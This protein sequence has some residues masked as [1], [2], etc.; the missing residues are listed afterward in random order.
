MP[1]F[2]VRTHQNMQQP[3]PVEVPEVPPAVR[4]ASDATAVALD[5]QRE[6]HEARERAAAALRVAEHND[7]VAEADA[8]RAG[9]KPPKPA[10]PGARDDLEAAERTF[11]LRQRLTRDAKLELLRQIAEHRD[12]WLAAT[13]ATA[14][15][16][17]ARVHGLLSDLEDA[18]TAAAS[19]GDAV[20]KL[21]AFDGRLI[22]LR[23]APEVGGN[24]AMLPARSSVLI[25][26]IATMAARACGEQIGA[27]TVD[28]NDRA[29]QRRRARKLAS[30]EANQGRAA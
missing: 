3:I 28:I 24:G 10:A 19:A 14:A 29:K 11:E 18:L 21:E 20:A 22:D 8:L 15:D 12:D 27:S 30:D 6:A 9:T 17:L 13:R 4:A 7:T 1:S 16:R 25:E 5:E 26:A 23:A 2:T